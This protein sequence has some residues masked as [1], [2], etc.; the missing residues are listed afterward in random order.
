MVVW[1]KKVIA[2]Y[3][4]FVFCRYEYNNDF[5]TYLPHSY[6]IILITNS[7]AR[8]LINIC[9]SLFLIKYFVLSWYLVVN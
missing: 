3:Y 1:S 6:V 4:R 8:L 7:A 2:V 5:F 9:I